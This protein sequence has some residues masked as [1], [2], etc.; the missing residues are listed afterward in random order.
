VLVDGYEVVLVDSHVAVEAWGS[1]H[2]RVAIGTRGLRGLRLASVLQPCVVPKRSTGI[3]YRTHALWDSLQVLHGGVNLLEK[4][5]ELKAR[6]ADTKAALEVQR[7][8]EEEQ[9]RHVKELELQRMDF[10]AK[11]NSLEVG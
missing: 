10:D 7:R 1:W 5:D 11:F 3:K 9:R 4:V 2:T 6:S 8:Q